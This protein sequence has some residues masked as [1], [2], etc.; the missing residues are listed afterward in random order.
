MA[1]NLLLAG[2]KVVFKRIEE[3]DFNGAT[4]TLSTSRLTGRGTFTSR[5]ICRA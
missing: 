2:E 1:S 5:Q 4:L 3:I